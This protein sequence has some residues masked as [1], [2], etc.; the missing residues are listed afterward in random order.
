MQVETERYLSGVTRLY[1]F[2]LQYP[3]FLIPQPATTFSSSIAFSSSFTSSW[4]SIVPLLPLLWLSLLLNPSSILPVPTSLACRLHAHMQRARPA[5]WHSVAFSAVHLRVSQSVSHWVSQ[6]V[7]RIDTREEISFIV[8]MYILYSRHS[9][10]FSFSRCVLSHSILRNLFASRVIRSCWVL[11][12]CFSIRGT[13]A[14]LL[15]AEKNVRLSRALCLYDSLGRVSDRVRLIYFQ[16]VRSI[17][18]GICVVWYDG[19]SKSKR[20]IGNFHVCKED[21]TIVFVFSVKNSYC[22]VCGRV[23]CETRSSSRR[24]ILPNKRCSDQIWIVFCSRALWR[25]DCF[26]NSKCWE[27]NESSLCSFPSGKFDCVSVYKGVQQW[28]LYSRER[29]NSF[30]FFR[31]AIKIKMWQSIKKFI[32][33]LIYVNSYV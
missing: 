25:N 33:Y 3:P 14:T 29:K 16:E 17:S 21:A 23:F 7:S 19:K 18:R 2:L 15:D 1:S 32:V 4:S 6:S 13:C 9:P 20:K 28:S 10:S 5:G 11:A 26:W 30:I 27:E 12:A 8:T 24:A 22:E 31:Y